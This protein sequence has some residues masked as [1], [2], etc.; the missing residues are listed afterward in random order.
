MSLKVEFQFSPGERVSTPVGGVGVVGM[1][2]VDETE[3]RW[4]TVKTKDGTMW[5]L[6]K[7]LEGCEGNVIKGD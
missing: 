7:E 6:D 5:W 3:S 2:A 4:C 1:C